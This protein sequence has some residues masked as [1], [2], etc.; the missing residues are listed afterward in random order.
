MNR[1]LPSL[2]TFSGALAVMLGLA[3]T[4]IGC[5]VLEVENP[6]SLVEEQLQTPRSVPA[7]A[8]GAEAAVARALGAVLAPYSTATDELTWIGSRDAWQQLNIGR[9]GVGVEAQAN[10]FSDAAYPYVTEARWMTNEYI[11]LMEGFQSEGTLPNDQDLVR[12]YLY[13]AIIY[14]GIA[15][16][17]DDFV[18]SDRSEPD[19]P[20]GS[21]SM[22]QLYTTA[23]GWVDNGLSLVDSGTLF[24]YALLG[25]RA[26][27]LHAQAVW[28]TLNPADVSNP[29]ANLVNSAEIVSAAQAALDAMPDDFIYELELTGSAP[30][31]VV[32][33]LSMAL[34]V[35]SRAELGFGQSYIDPADDG[36]YDPNSD[37]SAVT[38]TD[39][40]TDEVHPRLV[41]TIDAFVAEGQ[42]ADIPVV[43][44]REMH[45]ILAE[46][47]LAG[48]SP[49]FTTQIN[50]VRSLDG[51]TAYSGQVDDLELLISE[52]RVQLFLQGRRLA[53]HYRFDDPSAEWTGSADPVGTFLPI[54]ITEVRA[55]P[56]VD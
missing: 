10:E 17:Y 44:A 32:G 42:F 9:I 31:L 19:P 22:D 5:D 12:T 1:L 7:M 14:A 30:D 20:I 6:N 35:N 16:M 24:E 26:R 15:D 28:S 52:R 49:D 18:L 4:L 3:F 48:G 53:D 23:L 21:D 45:L 43:S 34:Q 47:A 36:T 46:A 27:I 2:S 40:I 33:D 13:G 29:S 8:N 25:M 56:N 55:N 39:P 38:Y 37:D 11:G 50:A 54:A 51:I 41:A